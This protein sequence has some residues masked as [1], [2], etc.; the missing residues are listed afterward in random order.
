M[1]LLVIGANGGVGRHVTKQA[2]DRGH[3]VTALVVDEKAVDPRAIIDKRDLFG[4]TKEDIRPFDAV[5]SCFGSGFGSDPIVNKT[6]CEHYV[7]LFQGEKNRII[8]IIGSGSLYQDE[9]H[10]ARIYERPNH[11]AFLV[12][13]SKNATDG[14][15]VLLASKDVNFTVVM[16]SINFENTETGTGK[17]E[18]GTALVPLYNQ[19]GESYCRYYDLACAMVDFAEKG[20]YNKQAVTVLSK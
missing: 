13:I 5:I 7:K 12:G 11:P 19:N 20:L 6:V 1:K 10:K 18:V 4:L 14:L 3:E 8:H 9:T 16:P 15:N 2:L 17:Y